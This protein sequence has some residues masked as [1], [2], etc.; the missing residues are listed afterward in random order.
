MIRKFSKLIFRF[1]WTNSWICTNVQI[2]F[3]IQFYLKISAN[4]SFQM[5]VLLSSFFF[6]RTCSA[7]AP[8]LIRN[9][10]SWR[11]TTT[12]T[13]A[14]PRW[15]VRTA[16]A[17]STGRTWE[18]ATG[19]ASRRRNA[20]GWA[21]SSSTTRIWGRTGMED[22]RGTCSSVSVRLCGYCGARGAETFHFSL[23]KGFVW[24]N[25]A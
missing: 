5:F 1:T 12:K 7:R 9:A 4:S 8:S 16:G 3:P 17:P 11:T 14:T 2:S 25:M 15:T 18:A 24:Q 22:T 20:C 6:L 21:D 13:R 19:R 23:W 10:S